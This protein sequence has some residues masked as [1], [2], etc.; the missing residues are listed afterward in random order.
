MRSNTQEEHQHAECRVEMMKSL[1]NLI[2]SISN[3]DYN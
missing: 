2:K 1:L 3:I